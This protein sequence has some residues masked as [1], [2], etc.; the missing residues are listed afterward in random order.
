MSGMLV[1]QEDKMCLSLYL[2]LTC[3]KFSQVLDA[4]VSVFFLMVNS[5]IPS[6]DHIQYQLKSDTLL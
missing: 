1:T 6:E 4:T 5:L 3:D 2:L